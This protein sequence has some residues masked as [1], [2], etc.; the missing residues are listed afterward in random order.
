M[1]HS[2][3]TNNLVDARQTTEIHAQ[4][5]EGGKPVEKVRATARIY[6]EN[7]ALVLKRAMTALG[8]G[9]LG[10]KS[11]LSSWVGLARSFSMW[12]AQRPPGCRSSEQD[13]LK[14]PV[15]LPVDASCAL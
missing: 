6:H 9:D 3:L 7:G 8:N 11:V 12:K 4:V 2:W 13:C 15:A 1:L 14:L 10:S 5:R